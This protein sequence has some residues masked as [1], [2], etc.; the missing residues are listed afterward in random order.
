MSK[1]H[2]TM[3]DQVPTLAADVTSEVVEGEVLVY[4]PQRASALFLNPSAAVIL[5]LCDGARSVTQIIELI[6][7]S[8]PDSLGVA[9]EVLAALEQL[10]E[11]GV[12]TLG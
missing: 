2:L 8:Y 1:P 12:L 7:T 4:H 11:T 5:G 6:E 10:Q 9:D 3:L